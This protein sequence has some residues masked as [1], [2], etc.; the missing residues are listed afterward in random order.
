MPIHGVL[1]IILRERN[2]RL[3]CLAALALGYRRRSARLAVHF[4]DI[5]LFL[6][7]ASVEV[8]L[9]SWCMWKVTVVRG[10]RRGGVGSDAVIGA[11]TGRF[12]RGRLK[13]WHV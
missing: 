6:G 8:D 4:L 13:V 2:D 12:A 9:Y 10:M 1:W 5:E 11:M 7:I 3:R